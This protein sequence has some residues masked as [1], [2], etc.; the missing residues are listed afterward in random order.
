[1]GKIDRYFEE[2]MKVYAERDFHAGLCMVLE[3]QRQCPDEGVRTRFWQACMHSLLGDRTEAAAALRAGIREGV[4]WS[5]RQLDGE[6]DFDA[7]RETAEFIEIRAE[8]QKRFL[9]KQEKSEPG[10]MTIEPETGIDPDK[11]LLA[12]HHKGGTA[13]DFASHWEP[14]AEEGG[15]TL[16]IPQ[17]SQVLDSRGY[18]WDD[19]ELGKKEIV[20]CIESLDSQYGIKRGKL[21]IAGASQGGRLAFEIAHEIGAP[22]LCVIP[23]FPKGYEG[24]VR[25]RKGSGVP[26]VFMLGERD[27]ANERSRPVIDAHLAGGAWARVRIMKGVGH[28]LPPDFAAPIAEVLEEIRTRR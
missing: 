16:V 12:I 5:P 23:S 15:W 6:R 14:L 13:R 4:W 22:F 24:S 3:A 26:G 28:H 19:V 1:M 27:G 18:C 25:G 11:C 7:V 8:C 20:K 21:L 9:E 2:L 10:F 17:S